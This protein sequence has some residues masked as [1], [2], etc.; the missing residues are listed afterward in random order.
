MDGWADDG[1][2]QKSREG[3]DA[4]QEKCSVGQGQWS[5]QIPGQNSYGFDGGSWARHR[6]PCSRH[7]PEQVRLFSW[8][9]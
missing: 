7:S 6:P 5:L 1:S 8:R 9:T 4:A 2:V 3:A